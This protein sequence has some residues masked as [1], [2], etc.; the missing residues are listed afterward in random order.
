MLLHEGTEFALYP[1]EGGDATSLIATGADLNGEDGE[2]HLGEVRREYFLDKPAL[3]TALDE[4][5]D[6][7]ACE[8]P[9][10]RFFSQ[11]SPSE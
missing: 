3:R 9:P 5:V 6:S 7:H 8:R 4:R 2:A 11:S 10:R 1:R